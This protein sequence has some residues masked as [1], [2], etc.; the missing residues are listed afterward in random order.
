MYETFIIKW[1]SKALIFMNISP[2]LFSSDGLLLCP[3][4][5][6]HKFQLYA[7]DF[8]P[9]AYH[10]SGS[11]LLKEYIRYDSE[12]LWSRNRRKLSSKIRQAACTK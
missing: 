4:S 2:K 12:L 1:S 5:F 6:R 7:G 10:F 9:S 3:L 11:R 8:K